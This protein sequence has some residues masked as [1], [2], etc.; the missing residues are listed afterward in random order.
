MADNSNRTSN[1][2]PR[3][4][5]V[6]T[7]AYSGPGYYLIP[8]WM[9]LEVDGGNAIFGG[10]ATFNGTLI[11][12]D[13]SSDG[14][15]R[16]LAG[17]Y[18]ALGDS[19]TSYSALRTSTISVNPGAVAAADS[20]STTATIQLMPADALIVGVQPASIWSGA[21]FD[22]AITPVVSAASTLVLGIANSTHTS[23]TPDAMNWK[24]TYLDPS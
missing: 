12:S 15:V 3:V 5:H 14:D 8:S 18:L 17:G 1:L 24:I 4:S 11:A 9:T 6:T 13:I 21:Y 7:K 10:T 22:L 19:A 20:I 23:V 2:G 16:I